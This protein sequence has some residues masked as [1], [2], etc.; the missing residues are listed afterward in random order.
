MQPLPATLSTNYQSV[1]TVYWHQ[2]EPM[3]TVKDSGVKTY[4]MDKKCIV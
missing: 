4:E 3:E 2:I 1:V